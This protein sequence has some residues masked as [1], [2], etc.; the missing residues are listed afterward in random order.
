MSVFQIIFSPTG[1]TKAVA[2]IFADAF[3]RD[4][5]MID[6][7][8]CNIAFEGAE[9]TQNDI[10]IFAVPAYG[11]RVPAIAASRIAQL[12]GNGA[13]A[14]LIAVYGNREFDDT[15][16]ELQD[17]TTNAGFV[18]FA[19][20]GAVAEHS[21]VRDFGAGRP[22]L[23]DHAELTLFAEKIIAA[24]GQ[25]HTKPLQLPGNR[26]YKE[27]GGSPAKPITNDNCVKCRICAAGCPAGAIPT[28]DPTQTNNSLCISCMRCV[29]LCPMEARKL[30]PAVEAAISQRLAPVC[31]GRKANTLYI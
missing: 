8:A 21:L 15:L 30:N 25:I 6:L 17:I 13:R 18:P 28:I 10:C 7:T 3:G 16:V 23:E 22:D 14:V 27:F 2:D 20:V 9:I 29:Y 5:R 4:V 24:A 31:K 11:G 1:G 19:A 12:K 26:P